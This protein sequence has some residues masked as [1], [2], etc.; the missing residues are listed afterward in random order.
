MSF[1]TI[2][3]MELTISLI[4]KYINLCHS[5]MYISFIKIFTSVIFITL[6]DGPSLGR[7]QLFRKMSQMWQDD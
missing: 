1:V 7:G 4:V 2:V 5:S 3:W 6:D